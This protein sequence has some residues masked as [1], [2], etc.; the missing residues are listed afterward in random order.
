MAAARGNTRASAVVSEYEMPDRRRFAVVLPPVLALISVAAAFLWPSGAAPA[1]AQSAEPAVTC[2]EISVGWRI[3]VAPAETP[4]PCATGAAVPDAANNPGLLADCAILLAAKD[5][6]RGTAA[7]NWDPGVVITAWD[8]V[9]VRG[10]PPRV[11]ELRLGDRWLMGTIPAALGNLPHLTTL[12]LAQNR[13]TGCLPRELTQVTRNDLAHLSLDPCELPSTTL[14]Y[15]APTT[16]GGV[17]DAGDYAFLPDPDDL[18][19][20]ITTYEGLRTGLRD[21]TT[22]GLVMH[23]NDGDG[24]SHEAFYDLVEANDVV[25][26]READG[27]W[28]RYVVREVHADPAGDPPRKLLTLQIYSHPYPDT[29]CTG[30][31][32][33]TGS[34]TFT[35]TPGWFSTGNL[36]TSPFWHEIF[37][38]V[39]EG[40]SGT[41]PEPATVTPIDTP[42]PLDPMPDPDLPPGWSG[43]IYSGYGGVIEGYYGNTDGEHLL[44]SI[45]RLRVWPW[46]VLTIGTDR[47]TAVLIDELRIIDGWPASV[48]YYNEARDLS[49]GGSVGVGFYDAANGTVYAFTS[50]S[51]GLRTD[52]EALIELA[53]QFLPDAPAGSCQPRAPAGGRSNDSADLGLEDCGL[54]SVTLTY[55]APVTTGA[56]PADGDYAFLT[57]PD[58]LTTIVTTYEGLRDGSTTGLVIHKNDSAGASQADFYDLVE[59]RDIVE[60]R[61]ADDCFVRYPVTEVKDDPAGDPP[62]KLLAV[63]VMTYAFTGCSGAI[64]TTGSRTITWSPANLQS[65]DMTIPIRHG[66]WQLRPVGWTGEV[67]RRAPLSTADRERLGNLEES[68]DPAVVRQ[69]PLWRDPDLPTGWRLDFAYTGPENAGGVTLLYEDAEGTWAADIAINQ[70]VVIGET[71]FSDTADHTKTIVETRIIDGHPAFVGYGLTDDGVLLSR[72]YVHIYDEAADVEYIV[73]GWHPTLRGTNIDGTIAIARSLY[74]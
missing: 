15:G 36:P 27:C 34:R 6:L 66:P 20:A 40:W 3:C 63:K 33:T 52:P 48:A 54:P 38:W 55:G 8:G 70:V 53:R 43:T 10:T 19:T 74:R 59:A 71:W 73:V 62:R 21:G 47:A 68:T 58:D 9:T 25:E 32:R 22:I 67:E 16:T 23:K 42:W 57:D 7:L 4:G 37:L 69:H 72:T 41:L 24:A 14:T 2:F 65:P 28:M 50:S 61:E 31:L 13:F 26:W 39:P 30:A 60:W 18:T 56:V 46:H 45:Y 5:A 35:W 12:R 1:A 29:G 11:T 17:T 44:V 64:D 49:F 51:A